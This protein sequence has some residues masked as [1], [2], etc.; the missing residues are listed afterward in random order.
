M[1]FDKQYRIF[2]ISFVLGMGFYVFGDAITGYFLASAGIQ[3]FFWKLAINSAWYM[4]FFLLSLF[5]LGGLK[6]I[7]VH[8]TGAHLTV[9]IM[10]AIYGVFLTADNLSLYLNSQCLFC[11]LPFP[12]PYYIGF[13]KTRHLAVIIPVIIV[14]IRDLILEKDKFIQLE[15]V[16][17]IT[18]L[19]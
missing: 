17:K 1:E 9:L 8:L 16:E 12:I 6:F 2:I 19:R 11:M 10:I 5:F 14:L 13:L 7:D 18:S 15:L 4:A 3:D